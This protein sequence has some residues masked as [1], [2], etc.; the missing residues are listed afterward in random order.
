MKKQQVKNSREPV[1]TLCIGDIVI[2]QLKKKYNMQRFG[3]VIEL[4]KH[5]LTLVTRTGQSI[6]N[7]IRLV[8]PILQANNPSE[9]QEEESIPQRTKEMRDIADKDDQ[10]QQ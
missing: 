8:M 5:D 10:Q 3:R 7:S 1:F 9:S 6:T 4:F 2:F